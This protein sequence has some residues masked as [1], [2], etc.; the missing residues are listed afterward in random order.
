MTVETLKVEII[1]QYKDA[2]KR[3]IS[4]RA[5][6]LLEILNLCSINTYGKEIIT[7][8][9]ESPCKVYKLL[10]Q[11]YKNK[12]VAEIMIKSLFIVPISNIN[13][14]LLQGYL[15]TQKECTE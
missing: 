3:H 1:N 15:N 13:P 12:T 10:Y 8:F 11:I 5:P 4:N 14:N 9:I 2:I 6:G 7:I